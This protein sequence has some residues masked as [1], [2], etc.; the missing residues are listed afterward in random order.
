M[1]GVAVKIVCKGVVRVPRS[2]QSTAGGAVLNHSVKFA[3]QRQSG[4]ISQLKQH[5]RLDRWADAP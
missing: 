1:L 2:Y 3:Q 4:R 5:R